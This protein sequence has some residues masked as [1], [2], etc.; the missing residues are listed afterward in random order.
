MSGHAVSWGRPP[1]SDVG[2]RGGDESH[3]KLLR[4]TDKICRLAWNRRF[5]RSG[6]EVQI[7]EP[8]AWLSLVPGRAGP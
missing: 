5:G 4:G 8:S 6:L 7:Q 3:F 2:V 1:D